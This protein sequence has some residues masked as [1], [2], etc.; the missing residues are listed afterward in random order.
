MN[1]ILMFGFFFR[2]RRVAL[3]F[4]NIHGLSIF[5][6]IYSIYVYVVHMCIVVLR[7]R[8]RECCVVE[9]ELCCGVLVGNC[10]LLRLAWHIHIHSTSSILTNLNVHTSD[11]LA[12]FLNKSVL[13]HR[14]QLIK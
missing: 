3:S 2:I 11:Y 5:L 4:T 13:P 7:Q 12:T 6:Y 10:A 14:P 9:C 8:E 1:M